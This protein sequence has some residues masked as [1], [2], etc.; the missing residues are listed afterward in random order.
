MEG[1]SRRL[2]TAKDTFGNNN[3]WGGLDPKEFFLTGPCKI[4][5]KVTTSLSSFGGKKD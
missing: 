2:T 4:S 5:E 1:S 3:P